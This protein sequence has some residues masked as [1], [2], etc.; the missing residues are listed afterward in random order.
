MS[1]V[2]ISAQMV[3]KSLIFDEEWLPFVC[4]WL[5]KCMLAHQSSSGGEINTWKGRS[6]PAATHTHTLSPSLQ[7][8]AADLSK[9]VF[10]LQNTNGHW[11]SPEILSDPCTRTNTLSLTH[12]H[13]CSQPTINTSN[14]FLS[15]R[16]SLVLPL[17]LFLFY[18]PSIFPSLSGLACPVCLCS[19]FL[20]PAMS[21]SWQKTHPNKGI[22]TL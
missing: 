11:C 9:C 13:T 22:K 3:G 17:S 10:V 2:Y 20:C 18:F 1:L 6:K 15:R 8:A 7:A 4:L 12:T 19:C 21:C 16:P 5:W 14:T